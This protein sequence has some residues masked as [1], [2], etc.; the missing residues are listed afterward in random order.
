MGPP[1]WFGAGLF[2]DHLGRPITIQQEREGL[3]FQWPQQSMQRLK[4][5]EDIFLTGQ[6]IAPK[7]EL[8]SVL[9]WLGSGA[10]KKNQV[11]LGVPVVL[12][13]KPVLH[14]DFIR[15]LNPKPQTQGTP[16]WSYG[17]PFF[18]GFVVFVRTSI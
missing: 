8:E 6:F 2:R 9:K 1:P 15:I 17:W 3:N 7:N 13:G 14:A 16:S 18:L 5:L 4:I 10:L 11:G 12:I